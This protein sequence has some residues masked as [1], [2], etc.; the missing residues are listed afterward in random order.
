MAEEGKKNDS[1]KMPLD[2]LV[3]LPP[4]PTLAVCRVFVLGGAKY[5]P[6][7]YRGGFLRSRLLAACLRHVFAYLAGQDTDPESNE[8]NLAHAICCLMMLMQNVLDG[9]G[10]DDRPRALQPLWEEPTPTKI[11]GPA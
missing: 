3:W 7:N 1:G 8:S 11:V 5:A 6:L 10:K 2:L 4:G 9:R